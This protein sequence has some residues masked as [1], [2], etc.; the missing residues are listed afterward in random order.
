MLTVYPN[1]YPDFSCIAS[2]CRHNCCVGWE[3][4]ID[5]ETLSCYR[6]ITDDMGKRLA[7]SVSGE[8]EPHFILDEEECCP[9]LNQDNLCDLI[10]YGG[11]EMLCQICSDHPR[12][13]NYLSERTEVGVGLCCE[14]AAQLILSQKKPVKLCAE[15]TVEEELLPEE[16]ELL[17]LRE[18][19]IAVAQDRSMTIAQREEQL[20]EKFHCRYPA[21]SMAEWADFYLK[22]E[23]MDEGWTGILE[24][25]REANCSGMSA[26]G[27]DVFCEQLLVYFLYRYVLAALEDGNLAEKI[28][29]SVLSTRMIWQLLLL[30]WD[31]REETFFDVLTATARMYSAEVEYSQDNLHALWD[32]LME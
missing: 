9:F 25:L 19:A 8:E 22:L 16:Q 32:E 5:P 11:E 28:A 2:R 7:V 24:E 10:L 30:R 1:Y 4:D 17:T 29:F 18:Q 3:I 31:R 12:F 15:G 14:A 20:L 23:R 27:K 21:K 26:E 6:Q 13:R